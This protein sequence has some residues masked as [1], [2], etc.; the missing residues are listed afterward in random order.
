MARNRTLVLAVGIL[1]G[2]ANSAHAQ[3]AHFVMHSDQGD[4]VGQ[5]QNWN[6][7]FTPAT[8]YFHGVTGVP[9]NGAPSEVLFDTLNNDFSHT[10]TAD[11]TSTQLGLPLILGSYTSAERAPFAT[12]G[13]PGLEISFDG[14][15]ANTLNGSFT[16][17]NF[18]YSVDQATDKY[19][20]LS[21]KAQFTQ[22]SE[23][24]APAL[25]GTFSYNAV[26]EPATVAALAMGAAGLFARRR[27]KV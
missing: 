4:Y 10:I 23:G 5:G 19:T 24:F 18:K 9:I 11:F 20:L 16:V 8:S 2:A 22:H 17:E 14:R 26:P 6:L 25:H 21:F 1:A 15:G 27:K 12:Q 3:Y 7:W 13:H